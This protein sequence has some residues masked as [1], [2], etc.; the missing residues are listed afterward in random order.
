M[1]LRRTYSVCVCF[2]KDLTRNEGQR[3]QQFFYIRFVAG[4]NPVTLP[5][6]W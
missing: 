4:E 2:F 3:N 5:W 6:T 1:H